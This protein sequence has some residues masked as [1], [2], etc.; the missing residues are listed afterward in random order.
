MMD[1]IA[2][3]RS[4]FRPSPRLAR[5]YVMLGLNLYAADTD[6]EAR[7]LFTSVQHAFVN[8]RRGRPTPLPP[9]DDDG[10]GR[11]EPA[12]RLLLQS[13]LAN[14]VV[15]SPAT[16]RSGLQAFQERTGADEIMVVTQM[17]THTARVRSYQI[18]AAARDEIAS[19]G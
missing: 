18:A 16:V 7:R 3:Y 19:A 4:A 14:A 12:E 15:G 2:L 9:P 13:V 17:F 8:L 10:E 1:A 5:P 6:A 11:F